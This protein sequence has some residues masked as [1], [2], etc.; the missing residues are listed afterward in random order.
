VEVEKRYEDCSSAEKNFKVAKK[1]IE[2]EVTRGEEVE[3]G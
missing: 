2:K 1:G 3:G